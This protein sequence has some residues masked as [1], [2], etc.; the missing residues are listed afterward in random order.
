MP[1]DVERFIF[2]ENEKTTPIEAIELFRLRLET[3]IYLDLDEKFYV[4][5]FRQNLLFVSS[6]DKSGYSCLFGNSKFS[7]YQN[8]NLVGTGSLIDNVYMLDTNAFFNELLYI[9]KRGTKHK[10]IDENFVVL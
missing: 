2:V 5:S 8:S 9:N 1:T 6:L 7:L 4:P 3:N 10:L